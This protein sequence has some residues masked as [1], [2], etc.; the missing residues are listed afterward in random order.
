MTESQLKR[1]GFVR[2]ENKGVI[3]MVKGNIVAH[4]REPHGRQRYRYLTQG[5]HN[6]CLV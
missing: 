2:G 1:L 3:C 6:I 5:T 4:M